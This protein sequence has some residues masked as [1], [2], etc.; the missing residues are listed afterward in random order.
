MNRTY[1][2]TEIEKLTGFT[3]WIIG[4]VKITKTFCSIMVFLFYRL[5]QKMKMLKKV[6]LYFSEAFNLLSIRSINDNLIARSGENINK[7]LLLFKNKF[8]KESIT[9]RELNETRLSTRLSAR[10]LFSR[11]SVS[12]YKKV[13]ISRLSR[14]FLLI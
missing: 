8:G 1:S 2:S 11:V 3:T 12:N 13:K 4:K 6:L 7:F 9:I 10:V 14:L 5:I